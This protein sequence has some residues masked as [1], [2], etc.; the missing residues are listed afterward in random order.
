MQT[1]LRN[2]TLLK[3]VAGK[4]IL[5]TSSSSAFEPKKKSFMGTTPSE[6]MLSPR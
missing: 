4:K 2:K 3:E 5:K 6:A 1:Y